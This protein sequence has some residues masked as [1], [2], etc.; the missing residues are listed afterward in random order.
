[1]ANLVFVFID[2][3]D[4]R[5]QLWL[6]NIPEDKTLQDLLD[7]QSEPGEWYGLRSWVLHDER[8]SSTSEKFEDK[9]VDFVIWALDKVGEHI[10][11]CAIANPMGYWFTG[12]I[13]VVEVPSE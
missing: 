13:F 1:M 3:S 6:V 7:R 4:P 11:I 12:P 9:R 2:R 8:V 10:V 5:G